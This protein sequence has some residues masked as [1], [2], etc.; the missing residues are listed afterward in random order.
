VFPSCVCS[1][2]MAVLTTWAPEKDTTLSLNMLSCRVS[3]WTPKRAVGQ[4]MSHQWY[5]QHNL[6][7]TGTAHQSD[8]KSNSV[9]SHHAVHTPHSPTLCGPCQHTTVVSHGR[10][11][12][13]APMCHTKQVHV[14][15]QWYSRA[16]CLN[17][18]PAAACGCRCTAAAPHGT[19]E[20][21][22]E[23]QHKI[24]HVTSQAGQDTHVTQ[25]T[26]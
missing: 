19:Y 5:G 12:C 21:P 4:P 11:C 18:A 15:Q 14:I 17:L 25:S 8:P 20:K 7:F 6:L 23:H 22:L 16:A 13:T 1:G 24:P 26:R 2:C 10:Q 3:S 9:K